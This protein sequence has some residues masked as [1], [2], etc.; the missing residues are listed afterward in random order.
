MSRASFGVEFEVRLGLTG[1][2]ASAY[3]RGGR[4]CRMALDQL[5]RF[6][7]LR[8][9]LFLLHLGLFLAV[10][11]VLLC[12][13]HRRL[14]FR[15]LVAGKG[16]GWPE[17]RQAEKYEQKISGYSLHRLTMNRIRLDFTTWEF[18]QKEKCYA[19]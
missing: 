1:L 14:N 9:H 3:G 12:L 6:L 16:E 13:V 11:L 7:L 4:V 17:E 8:L 5:F 18:D 19:G 2:D 15:G 10:F